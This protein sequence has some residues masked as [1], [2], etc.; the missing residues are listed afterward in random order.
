MNHYFTHFDKLFNELQ[1][2]FDEPQPQQVKDTCR[3]PKYPV[4]NCYLSEDQNSLHFEFAL[5]GY[6]EKEVKV[7]GG[8]NSFTVRAAKEES[9]NSMGSEGATHVLL[10]HG[11]SGKNVDFSMKVDEQYDTKK[12]KVVFE[13][14]L[15]SVTIPKAK[16]AESVMLFG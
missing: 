2:G 9:P 6:K 8:V 16:E 14:G 4:S 15:L 5:A 13:N 12:A 10:H 11:I 1:W 7:I 3:M